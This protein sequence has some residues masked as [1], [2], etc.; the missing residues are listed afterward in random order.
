VLVLQVKLQL[1]S[2]KAIASVVDRMKTV[3]KALRIEAS[4]ADKQIIIG[5]RNETVAIRTFFRDLSADDEGNA[6]GCLAYM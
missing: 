6:V 1:A 4:Q 5:V 2:A 3:A